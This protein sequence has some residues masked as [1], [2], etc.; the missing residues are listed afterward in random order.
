MQKQMSEQ[1]C[2]LLLYLDENSFCQTG[3]ALCY[4]YVLI[5]LKNQGEEMTMLLVVL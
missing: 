3:Y 1:R 5:L 2:S 4:L